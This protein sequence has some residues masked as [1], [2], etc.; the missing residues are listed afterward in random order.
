MLSRL[1]T[2]IKRSLI[3]SGRPFW[4][5]RF[6]LA[7]TKILC[8]ENACFDGCVFECSG[9]DNVIEL[10]EGANLASCHVV[11]S[12]SHNRIGIGKKTYIGAAT[13]WIEDDG[14]AIE[15]GDG[16]GVNSKCNFTCT[17]GH[18]L[19][20]GDRCLLSSEINLSVGD[21][22][23]IFDSAGNRLNQT[24]D[25]VIEN[26]VWIGKRATIL[27]GAHIPEDCVVATGAVVTKGFNEPHTILAGV[28]AKV[29]KQNI[30]WKRDRNG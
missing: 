25:I 12:G 15:I 6:G 9:T 7:G 18:R 11:I 19:T 4:M 3:L 22:H 17:E 14:N 8:E 5:N 29:V 1:K 28:P 26:R 23:G 13:F 2:R 20:I 27:K 10:K 30:T 24:S 16:V 21:G